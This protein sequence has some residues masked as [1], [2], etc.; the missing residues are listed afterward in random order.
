MYI[1][2]RDVNR[3]EDESASQA[4]ALAV[5][6]WRSADQAEVYAELEAQL[7]AVVELEVEIEVE[8]DT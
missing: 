7:E 5:S 1:V 6:L 4:Y 8:L 3:W 2:V